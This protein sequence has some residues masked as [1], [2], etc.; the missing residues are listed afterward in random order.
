MT[1]LNLANSGVASNDPS[2]VNSLSGRE[3][4]SRAPVALSVSEA[5]PC[6]VLLFRFPGEFFVG[7]A[8][9]DNLFH[10]SGKSLRQIYGMSSILLPI[11][12]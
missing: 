12:W 5:H 6:Y 4:S 7:H 8:T 3:V 2:L 1:S 11:L 9:T 10:N